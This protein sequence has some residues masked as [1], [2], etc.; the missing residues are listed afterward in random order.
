[1]TPSPF[2]PLPLRGRGKIRKEGLSPLSAG[3]SI[4]IELPDAVWGRNKKGCAPLR[5]PLPFG[6]RKNSFFKFP[7]GWDGE[8]KKA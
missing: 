8:K 4:G 2:I 5:R 3:Y 6:M 7:Y 1:M